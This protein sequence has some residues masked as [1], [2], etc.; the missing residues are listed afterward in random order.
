MGGGSFTFDDSIGQGSD[1]V[2]GLATLDL[3]FTWLGQTFTEASAT[4]WSLSF[5]ATGA[6]SSWGLGR[7]GVD[8]TCL[9]NCASSIGPTDFSMIGYVGAPANDATLTSALASLGFTYGGDNDG[10][11][12]F[13]GSSTV[14]FATLL[15]GQTIIAV[16]YGNGVGSPGRPNNSTQ[17]DGDDTA[18]YLFNAGTIGLDTFTLAFNAAST[19][20]LFQTG[21]P[22][23]P[24]GVPEPATWAMML[25]GFGAAGTALRRSR[26]KNSKL[27][28]IA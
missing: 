13:S 23:P 3:S 2:N 27:L 26:R 1:L 4:L 28:Q 12:Q 25:M 18:F 16:H 20:T 9:L 19:V 24:P 10:I 17:G 14:N 22:P 15:F 8:G 11:E 6:L 7:R 5:D 21:S